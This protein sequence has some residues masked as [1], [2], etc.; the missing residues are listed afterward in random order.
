MSLHA[1]FILCFLKMNSIY[2]QHNTN[3]NKT[4]NSEMKNE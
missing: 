4:V 1:D 3:T 2:L